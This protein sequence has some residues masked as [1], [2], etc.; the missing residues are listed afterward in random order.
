MSVR[1]ATFAAYPSYAKTQTPWRGTDFDSSEFVRLAKGK[2]INGHTTVRHPDT[3]RLVRLES[4]DISA[5]RELVG[6][7]AAKALREEYR[8]EKVLLVPIPGSKCVRIRD[9][10]CAA[11]SLAET[12]VDVSKNMGLD[13][14]V[15]DAFRWTREMTPSHQ[16]GSRDPDYLRDHLRLLSVPN[17][18]HVVLVDDVY[19]TGGHVKAATMKLRE[20]G[21]VPDLALCVGRRVDEHLRQNFDLDDMY[22]DIEADPAPGYEK[23]IVYGSEIGVTSGGL[24]GCA[25]FWM[26]YQRR[27]DFTGR[28]THLRNEHD[29][30]GPLGWAK[31]KGKRARAFHLALIEDFFRA[32]NL[33]FHCFT[34]RLNAS[35]QREVA[36]GDVARRKRF[37]LAMMRAKLSYFGRGNFFHFCYSPLLEPE[38]R[39]SNQH[40]A[41]ALKD[42][43]RMKQTDTVVVRAYEKSEPAKVADLLLEAIIAHR[44]K[45]ELNSHQEALQESVTGFLRWPDLNADTRPEE[46]KFNIWNHHGG[47]RRELRTRVAAH[48]VEPYP[49]I[50]ER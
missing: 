41:R 25:S 4:D 44:T 45:A 37:F 39:R 3:G 2:R 28:L 15:L 32:Q 11:V 10:E 29:Y 27:G 12:I 7:W 47:G 34:C 43:L 21:A 22:V 49:G 36:Q 26:P 20:V 50:A 16:G 13:V 31:I 24:H 9:R 5:A 35:E 1:V 46:W 8:E 14:R 23:Y 33:M 19:T 17:D 6:L 40:R 18:S 30:Q 42:S 48:G 38:D